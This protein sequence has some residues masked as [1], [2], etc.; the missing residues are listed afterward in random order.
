MQSVS[1]HDP[2]V[3]LVPRSTTGYLLETL[4]VCCGDVGKAPASRTHSKRFALFTA[5]GGGVRLA[6]FY[7][8]MSVGAGIPS[9]C[10]AYPTMIRWCRSCLAQPPA[11]FWKPSWFVAGMW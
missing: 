9:G 6:K 1:D 7:C 3:S 11:T 2:V 8:G 10:K 4:R 5:R